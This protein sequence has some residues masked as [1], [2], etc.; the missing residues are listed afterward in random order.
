MARS[1]WGNAFERLVNSVAEKNIVVLLGEG[2]DSR[3]VV[4]KL[5]NFNFKNLICFSYGRSDSLK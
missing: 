4:S 1:V 2:Y 3:Y 5:M